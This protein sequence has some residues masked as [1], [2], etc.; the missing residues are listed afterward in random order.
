MPA[1]RLN[2]RALFQAE[3][4]TPDGGG[5]YVVGW[6]DVLEV[7]ASL[8]PERG[9]ERLE[10]G[11]LEDAFGAILTIRSSVAALALTTTDRVTVDGEPWQ[12]RSGPA[13]QDQHGRYL[14]FTIERGVAV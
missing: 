9:R 8:E 1:G 2:K 6:S 13:N 5:G 12:I 4:S 10:A 3:T 14:T 11:R 7:W